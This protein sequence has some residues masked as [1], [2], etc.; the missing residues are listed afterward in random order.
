LKRIVALCA[1]LVVALAFAV[2][3]SAYTT[4]PK[5]GVHSLIAVCYKWQ[6]LGY[7]YVLGGNGDSAGPI[8]AG[9]PLY[10]RIAYAAQTQQEV[11]NFLKL[12]SGTFSIQDSS[13]PPVTVAAT[14]WNTGD[15]SFWTAPSK[16]S[17]VNNQG[18]QFTGFQ[19]TAYV[20]MGPAPAAGSYTVNAD[21]ELAGQV[22][23]GQNNQGPGT[24]FST[25]NCPMTVQ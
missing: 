13:S 5:S 3:A 20:P 7:P 15:T 17:L 16:A 25:T 21:I 1:G 6:Y 2:S 11:S 9:S 18:Q 22:F 23:D 8:T 12:Q 19:S 14:A 10:L 4:K 24:W